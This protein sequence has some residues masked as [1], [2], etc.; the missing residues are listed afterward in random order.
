MGYMYVCVYRVCA[1]TDAFLYV[2]MSVCAHKAH[3]Y[4][5]AYASVCY[6]LEC[7]CVHISVCVCVCVKDACPYRD[8]SGL[9]KGCLLGSWEEEGRWRVGQGPR[10]AGSQGSSL[11]KLPQGRRL[12]AGPA[13][14]RKLPASTAAPESL[15]QF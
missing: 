1:C 9:E 15:Q 12:G 14:D 3:V 6:C 8:L 7:M 2:C 11:C 13:E 5:R 10:G 4:A